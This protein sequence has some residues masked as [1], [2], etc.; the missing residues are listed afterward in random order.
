MV[1]SRDL[2]KRDAAVGGAAIAELLV[3]QMVAWLAI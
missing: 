2:L 1:L 3:C